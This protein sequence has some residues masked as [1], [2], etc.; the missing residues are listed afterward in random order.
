M[1]E[2]IFHRIRIVHHHAGSSR[3]R[4]IHRHPVG[5]PVFEEIPRTPAHDR[6]VRQHY[7]PFAG[8]VAAC[9]ID[10][11]IIFILQIKVYFA[12]SDMLIFTDGFDAGCQ[13]IHDVVAVVSLL[14]LPEQA[15]FMQRYFAA[16]KR[17]ANDKCSAP[18]GGNHSAFAKFLL[19]FVG[20]FKRNIVF[21][22]DFAAGKKWLAI[23]KIAIDNICTKFIAMVKNF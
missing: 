4:H 23:S 14:E 10:F 9:G 2:N 7:D 5:L 1:T 21:F 13:F 11:V 8:F 18:V 22:A 6:T 3:Q 19:D 17:I 12:E 15:D 16:I 20:C